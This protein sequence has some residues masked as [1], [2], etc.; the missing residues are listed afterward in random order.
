MNAAGFVIAGGKSSR[1]GRDK[2][3]LEI[4]GEPMIRR[5]IRAM[6]PVTANISIIANGPE[7]A[8]LGLPVFADSNVAIGP[9]EAI[10]NSLEHCSTDYALLVACDMPFVTS[11]L[12]E[13]LLADPTGYEAVV[14]LDQEGNLEPLC[15][16]YSAG[17][18]SA[19][20][21]IIKAGQRK[22]SLIY[23]LVKTRIVP[24]SEIEPLP[25]SALFFRNVNTPSDY[26]EALEEFERGST[27][28][29]H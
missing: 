3:W 20:T 14:P 17:V 26:L 7:Y 23:D 10:R 5:V 19:V 15:A 29:G 24:F 6:E 1:M 21:A 12:L 22:P 16:V 13:F 9:I 2:A 28:I 18:L 4:D 11:D 27:S 25:G 8:S